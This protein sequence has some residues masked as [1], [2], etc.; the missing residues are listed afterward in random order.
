MKDKNEILKT[1]VTSIAQ[2]EAKTGEKIELPSAEKIIANA[3]QAY[4]QDMTQLQK[5]YGYLGGRAKIRSLI[6][7]LSIPTDKIPVNLVS[8]EE[9]FCFALGQRI[10]QHRFLITQYHINQERM[11][12]D[13]EAK[14]NKKTKK[15]TKKK[16]EKKGEKNVIG[17]R[18]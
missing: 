7:I 18:K 6:A 5:A 12:I 2:E 14:I 15:K 3:T 13:K 10:I 9:K 11:K 1:E 16:T 17:K 8:E 4:I